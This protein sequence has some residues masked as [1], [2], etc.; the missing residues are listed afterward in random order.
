MTGYL[1][2]GEVAEICRGTTP[3]NTTEH[4]TGIGFFG[5]AE[6]SNGGRVS[7][8]PE[9]APDMDRAVTLREGDIVMALL[10]KI[11]QVAFV[12]GFAA[13]SV[14]GRECARIRVRSNDLGITPQWLYIAL[15]STDLRDHAESLATGSTMPRLSTMALAEI[16]F[17]AP[18]PGEP[19]AIGNRLSKIEE[20]ITA[21]E[22]V[23]SALKALRAAEIDLTLSKA[24]YYASVH[25]DAATARRS[26]E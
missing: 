17:P 20:A 26:A 22:R 11:G 8:S 1:T 15:R 10:G 18:P 9:L 7:R 5:L 4:Y 6:I 16:P 19:D 21:N 13:G 3:A 24:A 25:G 12:G 2:I 23:V 14:L